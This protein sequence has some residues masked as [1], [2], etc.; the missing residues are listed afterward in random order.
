MRA[1]MYMCVEKTNVH[2]HNRYACLAS[3]VLILLPNFIITALAAL[4]IAAAPAA[5]PPRRLLPSVA[6]PCPHLHNAEPRHELTV[7]IDLAA[8][9]RG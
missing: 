7:R 6:E 4:L 3:T 5:Q 8:G 1:Y 9:L 2:T